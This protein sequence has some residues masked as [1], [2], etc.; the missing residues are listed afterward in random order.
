MQK[1]P[2][3]PPVRTAHGQF[4]V[5]QDFISRLP[6]VQLDRTMVR[7]DDFV[8][9]FSSGNAVFHGIGDEEVVD[10]PPRIALTRLE[11]V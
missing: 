7:S 11:A 3:V 6:K 1:L 9:D 5:I 10:T 4:I 2:A 8:M